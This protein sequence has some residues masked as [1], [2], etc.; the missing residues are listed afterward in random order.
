MIFFV[1]RIYYVCLSLL[2]LNR[3]CY[4]IE[5]TKNDFKNKN[6]DLTD[7]ETVKTKIHNVRGIKVMLDSDL[8]I[9]YNLET[10]SLKR[11]VKRNI[12]RFPS[13]FMLILTVEEAREI[14]RYQNGTLKQGYNIKYPP[15]AFTEQGVAMLSGILNSNVAVEINIRIMR[16][17]I[18]LRKTIA[19]NSDYMQLHEKIKSI[20]SQIE[21]ISNNSMV[22]GILIEKKLNNMSAD[23]RRI[24]ETLDQFHDG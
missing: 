1:K 4:L 8:A 16:A 5:M 7:I 17:F 23:I 19:T 15:Y 10:K 24:S 11:Q 9:L 6:N 14:S 21:L 3:G 20:E 2:K 18:E 13:D 12:N 22:D